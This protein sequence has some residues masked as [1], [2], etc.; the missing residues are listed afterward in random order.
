MASP[1]V[2]SNGRSHGLTNSLISPGATPVKPTGAVSLV[3]LW[4]RNYVTSLTTREQAA[5]LKRA[6]G[7]AICG[8]KEGRRRTVQHLQQRLQRSS[9]AAWSQTE[10]L[11]EGEAERHGIQSEL[12]D[13][14][15]IAADSHALF[16]TVL[17]AYSDRITPR[18]V[19]VLI[20]GAFGQI[21]QKYTQTDPRVLGFVSM[22]FHYTGQALLES[23]T[24]AERALLEPYFKVMD[25]H[26]YMPLKAAYEAAGKHDLDSPVLHAVQQLLPLSTKIADEVCRQI[27]RQHGSYQ[28]YSGPLSSAKV[29]ISSL[30]DVEM[31][32]V[33]LCLCALQGNIQSVQQE[34]F[35]LCV[36]LYPRLQVSW[37]L[38]RDM[39]RAVGWEM[40]DR[41]SPS[42]VQ[43]FLP[44]LSALT[45]MFS[46][47]LLET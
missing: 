7:L 34:L 35:P 19:S 39:L 10:K 21:R 3:S 22:Q 46:L 36:M 2:F 43:V 8:S 29:K 33:Y 42:D 5:Q 45:E 27:C 1:L 25:D 32:Q 18:R 41:L 15:A 20:S 28:S 31:F 44:Y 37:G 13:P 24:V 30:R 12:I 40:H 11:L 16:E 6:E 47:D 23:V 4:A 17:Q 14:W 26:L 9:A 38:V